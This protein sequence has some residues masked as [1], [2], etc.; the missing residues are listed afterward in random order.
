MVRFHL[1]GG[2][3][4]FNVNAPPYR[5]TILKHVQTCRKVL[6]NFHIAPNC[7]VSSQLPPLAKFLNETLNWLL[8]CSTFVFIESRRARKTGKHKHNTEFPKVSAH[9]ESKNGEIKYDFTR[10]FSTIL[11]FHNKRLLIL[12]N[13]CISFL[14]ISSKFC[15]TFSTVAETKQ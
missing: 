11:E 9:T 2:G 15:K 12:E 8:N 13:H 14:N 3:C 6:Y 4:P 7:F 10:L 5:L 1:G